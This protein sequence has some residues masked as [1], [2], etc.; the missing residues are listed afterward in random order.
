MTCTQVKTAQCFVLNGVVF[1]GRY[2]F[3]K[4]FMTNVRMSVISLQNVFG[5]HLSSNGPVRWSVV[6]VSGDT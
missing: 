1:L 2:A 6:S 5:R 3:H 4:V